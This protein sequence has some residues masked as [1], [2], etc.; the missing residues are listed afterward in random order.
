MID[1]KRINTDKMTNS[2]TDI[3]KHYKNFFDLN[4]LGTAEDDEL[5]IDWATDLVSNLSLQ[6]VSESLTIDDQFEIMKTTLTTTLKHFESE[7]DKT[8]FILDVCN[9]YK[10]QLKTYSR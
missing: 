8:D 3:K 5:H 7:E 9:E 4:E 2:R 1:L 6:P 10:E